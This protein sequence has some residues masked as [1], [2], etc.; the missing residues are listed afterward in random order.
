MPAISS[1]AVIRLVMAP[2]TNSVPFLLVNHFAQSPKSP[3]EAKSIQ[4]SMAMSR[5]L[6]AFG[7]LAVQN[8]SHQE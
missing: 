7:Y 4:E 2:C 5:E 6:I 3:L 1:M 8:N